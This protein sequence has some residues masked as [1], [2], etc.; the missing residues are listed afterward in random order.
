[1]ADQG[2]GRC[3]PG[4]VVAGVRPFVRPFGSGALFDQGVWAANEE[5]LLWNKHFSVDRTLIE[6]AANLKSF[7]LK[8]GPS[9]R[10]GVRFHR[11]AYTPLP[12]T[13]VVADAIPNLFFSS[14]LVLSYSRRN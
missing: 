12:R 4:T 6:T 10:S 9:P 11:T 8:E 2:S 13:I 1:M 5:R 7:R 14:L 3:G